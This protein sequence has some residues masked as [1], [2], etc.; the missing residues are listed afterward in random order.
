MAPGPI[1][2]ASKLGLPLVLM[3]Y[4]FD[5]PWRLGSWDRFALPRPCS[6]ARGVATG[7]IYVP[8]DLDR[9][10]LEHFRRR[11]EDLLNRLTDEAEAWAASGRR[12]T[13]QSRLWRRT[14]REEESGK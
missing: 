6:R 10:G 4:G 1:F 7:E 12:K 5:R 9:E 11:T 2:L 14:G 3:G 13:G 8:P